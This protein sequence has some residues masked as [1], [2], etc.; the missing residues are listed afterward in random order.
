MADESLV[1]IAGDRRMG[2]I[3][4][5]DGRL[6]LTYDE[7]WRSWAGAW[8]LSLSMPL[9]SAEHPHRPVEAFL[10]G[11]L[12]DNEAVIG[13]WSREFHVSPRNPFAL[14]GAVGEDCAGA[15]QF[16]K[17]GRLDG[18]LDGAEDAIDWLE[19][20][21]VAERLRVLREDQTAWRFARDNGQFSLAG[22]QPKT[23][24]LFDGARWG[25]PSGRTPTTHILKPPV[26]DFD[27]HAENEHLCLNLARHLG[28]PA[29]A[30][31]VG[32]FG[33]E[34]AIV[35]QRYDRRRIGDRFVRVHQEDFCQALSH[36]PQSKYQNEGGPGVADCVSLLAGASSAGP[37]DIDA[38]LDAVVFNWI[39][40]GTDAHAK[41]YSILIAGRGQVRLAPLYDV[42]SALPYRTLDYQKLKL[43]MKFGGEYRLGDIGTRHIERMA[44]EVRQGPDKW[45]ARARAMADATPGAVE[46]VA[47]EMEAE[48]LNHAIIRTLASAIT[49]R[50][51][52]LGDDLAR[53]AR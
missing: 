53:P 19:E 21:D 16:V 8:P 23:A 44:A 36:P 49:M 42:S 20:A 9:A 5:R 13:R 24:L 18:F 30:S 10:W 15:V 47:Q 2:S 17:P 25:V 3:R 27:G 48:G 46:Q 7:A 40:A 4:R 37:D 32:R 6:S 29:A 38:F 34:V 33:D 51:G 14:I 31:R 12:P 45:T 26:A 50:A 43:A 1:L 11:L 52:T 41:N 22:A 35:V 28:L 39:I